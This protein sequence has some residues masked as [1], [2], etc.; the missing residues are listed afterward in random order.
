MFKQHATARLPTLWLHG[1]TVSKLL[2]HNYICHENGSQW[3]I[4][5]HLYLNVCL[6]VKMY[7]KSGVNV[8]QEFHSDCKNYTG[9]LTQRESRGKAPRG[10]RGSTGPQSTRI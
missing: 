8:G 1:N 7:H 2:V 10:R 6:C 9:D 3:K 4:A 5:V